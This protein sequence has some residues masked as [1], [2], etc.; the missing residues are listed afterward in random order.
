[1]PA[2]VVEDLP[3]R[4]GVERDLGLLL[5][6]RVLRRDGGGGGSSAAGQDT[7]DDRLPVQGVGQREPDRR[8]GGHRVVLGRHDDGAEV[9]GFGTDHLPRLVVGVPGGQGRG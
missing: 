5:V 4:V 1:G 9:G 2:G 6:G 7:V 3:G 8:V